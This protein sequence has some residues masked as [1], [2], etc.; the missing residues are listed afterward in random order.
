MHF[1]VAVKNFM[2]QLVCNHGN[3]SMVKPTNLF[4]QW[5]YWVGVLK[6]QVILLVVHSTS[7]PRAVA[8]MKLN[9]SYNHNALTIHRT[10]VNESLQMHFKVAVK[11]FMLLMQAAQVISSQNSYIMQLVCFSTV[12]LVPR[13]LV[14]LLPHSLGTRL[15]YSLSHITLTWVYKKPALSCF[16]PISCN[17]ELTSHFCFNVANTS[18]A[19]CSSF[20]HSFLTYDRPLQNSTSLKEY[21]E[22]RNHVG[23]EHSYCY[24]LLK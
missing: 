6:G 15:F 20:S 22:C 21:G 9:S 19:S 16:V 18:I 4:L 2:P 11:N 23:V 13:P 8:S 12:S 14:S 5:S 17:R 10:F 1:K 7:R 24:E 3:H